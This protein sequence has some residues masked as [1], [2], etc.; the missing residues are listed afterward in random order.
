MHRNY[1]NLSTVVKRQQLHLIA[2]ITAVM[3]VVNVI[4]GTTPATIAH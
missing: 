2:I 4:S 1:V 3:G